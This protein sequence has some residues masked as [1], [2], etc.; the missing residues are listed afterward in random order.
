MV[1]KSS[2]QC[3]NLSDFALLQ[4]YAF[5]FYNIFALE[6]HEIQSIFR[7]I[8]QLIQITSQGQVVLDHGFEMSSKSDQV[9]QIELK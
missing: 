2:V 6:K 3:M 1:A 7:I 4:T 9:S 5:L 8:M